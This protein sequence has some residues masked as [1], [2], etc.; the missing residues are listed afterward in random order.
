MAIMVGTGLAA[1]RGILFKNAVALE[2]SAR[3][4]TVVMD[5]TGTLTSGEPEVSDVVTGGVAEGELLALAAAVERES[6]H[7]LARAVVRR[8]DGNGATAARAE[9][10]EAVPGQG[11]LATVG[12]RRV[13]VGNQ[14]LMEREKVRLDALE[15]RRG[16]LAAEGKTVMY[17]AVDG[18]AAGLLAIADAARPTRSRRW[19][20]FVELMSR[21]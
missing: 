14:R 21:S 12:D 3:I 11:A 20:R 4:T 9:A 15:A 13:A 8:A 10:F 5:K 7:P 17:V 2:T 18:R 1:K 19:T 16:E 6:E